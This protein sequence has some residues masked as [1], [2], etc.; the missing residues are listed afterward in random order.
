[1]NHQIFYFIFTLTLTYREFFYKKLIY[2]VRFRN[3]V[4]VYFTIRN[5]RGFYNFCSF[6]KFSKIIKKQLSSLKANWLTY[7]VLDPSKFSSVA[8]FNLISTNPAGLQLFWVVTQVAARWVG[9]KSNAGF[10]F[11]FILKRRG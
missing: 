6:K 11:F 9:K 8:A 4:Y 3:Q 7:R 1:M 10:Q 2:Q 5:K